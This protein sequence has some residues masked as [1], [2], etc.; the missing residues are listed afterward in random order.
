M[1]NRSLWATVPNK[2]RAKAPVRFCD[3][4]GWTDV[5]K[6]PKTGCVLNFCCSVRAQVTISV[7]VANKAEYRFL[8]HDIDEDRSVDARVIREGEF[9]GTSQLVQAVVTRAVRQ[10]GG[11]P[12]SELTRPGLSGHGIDARYHKV[13]IACSSDALPG[14]GVGGSSGLTVSAVAALNTLLRGEPGTA[15]EIAEE[16][17]RAVTEDLGIEAGVQDERASAHGGI[18]YMEVDFPHARVQQVEIGH[19]TRCELDRRF[20]IAYSGKSHF[21]H[22]MHVKVL[23]GLESG[24]NLRYFD[25]LA[26]C[27]RLG[28]QA[29]Y[30]G[31]LDAFGDLMN[32]NWAA[33][34]ALHPDITT[35]EIEQIHELAFQNGAIGFKANGAGGGGTVTILA[36]PDDEYWHI[37]KAITAA[38]FIMM[39]NQLEPK[40]VEVW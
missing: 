26:N 35:R 32:R 30:D 31:D 21:S 7:E 28:R 20:I 27:A 5:K 6:Y 17:H 33:Q 34:K 15:D 25:E 36:G 16:A 19:R 3:L 23:S 4:G 22:D 18:C 40:G 37:K 11:E 29:L 38:G 10:L 39:P 8:S 13:T 9:Q 14:S 1:S 12:G 24:A 2:V